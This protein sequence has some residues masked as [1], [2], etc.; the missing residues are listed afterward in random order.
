MPRRDK[1]EIKKVV[2]FRLGQGGADTSLP[3]CLL[4][5]KIQK[6]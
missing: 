3:L 4:R 5:E 6:F 1:G 2:D